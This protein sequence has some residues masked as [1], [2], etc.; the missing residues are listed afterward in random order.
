MLEHYNKPLRLGVSDLGGPILTAVQLSQCLFTSAGQSCNHIDTGPTIQALSAI[1]RHLLVD[2][3]SQSMSIA[4]K[5]QYR[6]TR[7]KRSIK[8]IKALGLSQTEEDWT[9]VGRP[10]FL[11]Y[12]FLLQ[13][14]EHPFPGMHLYK[15]RFCLNG[16]AKE[17]LERGTLDLDFFL[18]PQAAQLTFS[19]NNTASQDAELLVKVIDNYKSHG[20]FELA[21]MATLTEEMLCQVLDTGTQ[22][23]D[24][25]VLIALEN[26]IKAG[27]RLVAYL[28][29]VPE[30]YEGFTGKSRNVYVN[31]ITRRLTKL[32]ND[33]DIPP[34]RSVTDPAYC[35]FRI[36]SALEGSE[37][38]SF[39]GLQKKDG[40]F[41]LDLS[42][43][44]YPPLSG[45]EATGTTGAMGV[46]FDPETHI[47]SSQDVSTADT[48]SDEEDVTSEAFHEQDI[49]MDQGSGVCQP[50]E[51]PEIPTPDDP[52]N[53]CQP[54]GDTDGANPFTGP[55]VSTSQAA[56][57]PMSEA[58]ISADLIELLEWAQRP[59]NQQLF[60]LEP[61]PFPPGCMTGAQQSLTSATHAL[62][63]S[64]V[65]NS[66]KA[67]FNPFPAHVSPIPD[68]N[69]FGDSIHSL[70][71]SA[72]FHPQSE[73]VGNHVPRE[74]VP[75]NLEYVQD[76]C[77]GFNGGSGAFYPQPM[78]TG[79]EEYTGLQNQVFEGHPTQSPYV[80]YP[81]QI[82]SKQPGYW[83]GFGPYYRQPPDNTILRP[84][85]GQLGSFSSSVGYQEQSYLKAGEATYVQPSQH[86]S[87]QGVA[88]APFLPAQIYQEGDLTT[89]ASGSMLTEMTQSQHGYTAMYPNHHNAFSS[90]G[91]GG[92]MGDPPHFNTQT[93]NYDGT[94][95]AW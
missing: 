22:S 27:R 79:F 75:M 70:G 9:R 42:P 62:P 20:E 36:I 78:P 6:Q 67:M 92:S 87:F 39:P 1:L 35:M 12:E 69:A 48:S 13:N 4:A 30:S 91:Y 29:F 66:S 43:V 17:E 90:D 76:M 3:R 8:V 93:Y 10:P 71:D 21:D 18:E 82:P 2:P 28:S 19:K 57:V 49:V 64:A 46:A 68:N 94:Y 88:Q 55:V 51:C 65:D 73:A 32:Y 14:E 5:R 23:R 72:S 25:D 16:K 15:S 85:S 41:M 53:V 86:G 60:T 45:P 59:E 31:K 24:G 81:A 33:Q 95:G 54:L 77:T 26:T 34:P 37:K 52:D 80:Q 7:R 84:Q 38:A 44:S 58:E 11:M 89:G 47:G 56:V 40:L 74:H 61:G 63:P 83:Q 50:N